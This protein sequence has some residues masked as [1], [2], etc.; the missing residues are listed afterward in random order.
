MF[1]AIAC[2]MFC[3]SPNRLMSKNY[4]QVLAL[5]FAVEKINKDPHFLPNISLGFRLYDNYYDGEDAEKITIFPNY[6]CQGHRKMVAVIGGLTS[7]FSVQMD[8][9]LGIYKLPQISYGS[10]DPV[11]DDRLKFPSLYLQFKSVIQLLLHFGWTWIGFIASA[12]GRSENFLYNLEEE[13]KKSGICHEYVIL[14]QDYFSFITQLMQREKELLKSSSKIVFVYGDSKFLSIAHIFSYSTLA[15][16]VWLTMCEWENNKYIHP[17]LFSGALSIGSQKRGIPGFQFFLQSV[18]PNK[19]PDDIFMRNFWS[20]EFD[21]NLPPPRSP[22]PRFGRNWCT[23]EERLGGPLDSHFEMNMSPLSYIIF[24]AV[25][26]LAK[27]LHNLSVNRFYKCLAVADHIHILCC[28]QLHSVLKKTLFNNS[29]VEDAFLNGTGELATFDILNWIGLNNGSLVSV[30]IGEVIHNST[31]NYSIAINE[32]MTLWN[33]KFIQPPHSVCSHKCLPGFQ[34]M[35]LKNKPKCCFWCIECPKGTISNQSDMDSCMKCKEDFYPNKARKKCIPKHIVF[36]SYAEPLGIVSASIALYFS[37]LS[38]L[39]LGIFIK[40]RDSPTIKANNRHLSYILLSSLILC[41][42][43][44]L[45]FIGRPRKITCI[46]RQTAFG[47]IF[48]V[49]LATILAKTITVVLAFKATKPG[50]SAQKWLRPKFSYFFVMVCFLIQAVICMVWL[51]T[52]PP[53]PDADFYS[54]PGHIILECNEGSSI[55]FYSI[56]GYMGLLALVSFIV[57][58]LARKLPNVFNEAKF[59]TFSMLVFCVVW[60]SFIPAYLSTKGKYIMAVEIFSILASSAGLLGCIF[61]PKCYVLL[62]HLDK[63]QKVHITR[64]YFDR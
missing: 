50:S 45:L 46:L 1:F 8:N 42:L 19:Y 4:Q 60:I 31:K 12:Y 2:K 43:C 36:L 9:V 44:S 13:M 7:G 40:H 23:G 32:K 33:C 38:A 26:E 61:L 48:S 29:A 51:G 16:K 41:F 39:V 17:S 5:V 15:G 30:N 3:C 28:I 52:S 6:N 58:F 10:S 55:A 21:C 34:K 64:K 53:F 35:L 59:I 20:K 24:R 62:L 18:T 14:F 56:L 27:T 22:S 49:S 37:F 11:L 57:A 54:E 47:I 25:L 63:N